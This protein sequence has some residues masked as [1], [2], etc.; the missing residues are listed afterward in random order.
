[1]S[2][3][4]TAVVQPVRVVL[5]MAVPVE[6]AGSAEA[7]MVLVTVGTAVPEAIFQMSTV[8]VPASTVMFHADTV[9]A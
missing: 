8:A 2:L 1:M 7:V 4:V 9:Q 3:A 5:W 6:I